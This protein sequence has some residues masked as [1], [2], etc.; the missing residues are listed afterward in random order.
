MVSPTH[1][2]EGPK[3]SLAVATATK[4]CCFQRAHCTNTQPSREY[5][6]RDH[7]VPQLLN[8][9]TREQ[10]GVRDRLN[11]HWGARGVERY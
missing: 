11:F 6:R 2:K 1:A 7:R 3:F 4:T 8:D 9:P 5:L 10:L